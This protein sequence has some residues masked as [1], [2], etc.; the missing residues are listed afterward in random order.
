[1]L[2]V[3][4]RP[5]TTST[6]RGGVHPPKKSKISR[7]ARK[8]HRS[9][10]ERTLWMSQ[11]QNCR[12]W[13][14]SRPARDRTS[15]GPIPE[16]LLALRSQKLSEDGIAKATLFKDELALDQTGRA[17]ELSSL[18]LVDRRRVCTGP[19]FRHQLP[20]PKNP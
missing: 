13:S 9:T 12:R 16:Q 15:G 19:R 20:A 8:E 5:S 4:R 17:R 2:R 10:P 14:G 18:I 3:R 6:R 11:T 7:R 1:M